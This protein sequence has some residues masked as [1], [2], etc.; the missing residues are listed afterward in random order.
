MLRERRYHSRGRFWLHPSPTPQTPN[1]PNELIEAFRRREVI[2]FAGAGLSAQAGLP[3]WPGFVTELAKRVQDEKLISRELTASWTESLAQQDFSSVA[4][5]I[6]LTMWSNPHLR[7][8]LL[9]EIQGMVAIANHTNGY[10]SEAHRAVAE[11]PFAAALTTNFDD[12]LERTFEAPTEDQAGPEYPSKFPVLTP[13]DGDSIKS[14]L[15]R[16]SADASSFFV[17]HLYGLPSNESTFLLSRQQFQDTVSR[18]LPFEESLNTILA[19][20]TLFFV[21]A[22]L[23][24]IEGYLGGLR[25]A[26]ATRKHYALL[27]VQGASWRTRAESLRLRFNIEVIPYTPL[28]DFGGLPAFLRAIRDRLRDHE[29]VAHPVDTGPPLRSLKLVN[30]GG[31]RELELTFD[32][33]HTVLLGGN[34]VGKSTILR[35]I[36][37][38]MSG[39]GYSARNFGDADARTRLLKTGQG[40]GRIEITNSAG[41]LVIGNLLRTSDGAVRLESTPP[42]PLEAQGT[43]YVACPS[44]RS[45]S[46]W[47]QAD[48]IK[49]GPDRP[50]PADLAPILDGD[51]ESRAS[52][53]K[54]WLLDLDYRMLDEPHLRSLRDDY[55]HVLAR[56]TEGTTLAF[57]EPDR[58]TKKISVNTDDGVVPVEW[59]SQG[60]GSLLCWVGILMRRLS[61]IYGVRDTYRDCPAVIMIDE[62]DAHMHPKWQRTLLSTLRELFPKLQLI[63]ATHSPLVISDLAAESVWLFHREEDGVYASRPPIDPRMLRTEA[64]LTGP[65]FGLDTV[66]GPETEKKLLEYDELRGRVVS[67][68]TLDDAEVHRYR[69]L[70][71]YLGTRPE[72][73]S[74]QSVA[75]QASALIES[76]AQEKLQRMSEEERSELLLQLGKQ[77]LSGVSGGELRRPGGD[78]QMKSWRPRSTHGGPRR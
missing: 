37:L 36:A 29:P 61:E 11:I 14:L 20:R 56:L 40:S 77:I 67:G 31:F 73:S 7:A 9:S 44:L 30:I 55:F 45:A 25:L 53:V 66:W 71:E 38:A 65:I 78:G 60:M 62:I 35:A 32:D 18:N 15:S 21:G 10:Y 8:K 72:T 34:G 13:Q 64:I 39:E 5:A 4:D 16:S 3:I 17:V 6:G 43:P 57:V 1:P 2:L 27:D 74:E 75:L 28:V 19:T 42:R 59:V 51:L 22:S 76:A 54:N 49:A 70:S 41:H 33:L 23:A 26:P 47:S 24:G 69:E 50:V 52:D 48:W 46:V 12:L 58:T 63:A 68:T